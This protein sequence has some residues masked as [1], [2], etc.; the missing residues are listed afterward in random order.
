MRSAGL[1]GFRHN[2]IS[3]MNFYNKIVLLMTLFTHIHILL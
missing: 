2:N 1:L 3:D